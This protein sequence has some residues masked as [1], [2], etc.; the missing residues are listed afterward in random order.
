MP[1]ECP[2]APQSPTDTAGDYTTE[3][4]SSQQDDNVPVAQCHGRNWYI[5]DMDTTK[6]LKKVPIRQWAVK[7]AF[8]EK[9]YPGTN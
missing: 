8:G 7:D 9:V 2:P 5:A 6:K 3:D 1:I 4:E